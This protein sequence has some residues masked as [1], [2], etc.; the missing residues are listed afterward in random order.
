[1]ESFIKSRAIEVHLPE[2]ITEYG[3]Y[4][5]KALFDDITSEVDI[6]EDKKDNLI[7]KYNR[8]GIT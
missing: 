2:E 3:R 8:V 6:L 7:S 4:E 1:M 5:P